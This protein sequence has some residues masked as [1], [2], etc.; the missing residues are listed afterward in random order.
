MIVDNLDTING[1]FPVTLI[2]V[3]SAV[4]SIQSP[5]SELL[6]PFLL[7]CFITF[8]QS[9]HSGSVLPRLVRLLMSLS[10]LSLGCVVVL[11]L[12]LVVVVALVYDFAPGQSVISSSRIDT[13]ELVAFIVNFACSLSSF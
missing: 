9:D 13:S 1:C 5:V 6:S 4:F 3:A 11:L 2:A 12:V 7:S 10:S 8:D